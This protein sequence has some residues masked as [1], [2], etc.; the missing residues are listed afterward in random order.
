MDTFVDSSWYFYRYCDPHN[1]HAAYDSG[2]VGYWFPIDQYIGGITHAILHLLY[3]R[4]WCK[5]MRDLGLVTHTEPIARLFTQGM[6]LKGGTAMSKSKGNIVGALDMAEKYGADTGR[7][8]MLF[9]NQPE[10]DLEWSE[11]S[12]E[13][14]WRFVNK[15]YRLVEQHAAELEKERKLLRKTHETLRRV[16]QDFDVRW[17]F[18]SAIALIMELHNEIHAAEP[19]NEGVRPEVRKEVLELLTLML[20]PLTPHLA[21]ELWEM[22][23][24]AGGLGIVKWPAFNA[25]LAKEDEVEIVVQVNGRVRGK[26]VVAAGLSEAGVVS[27][28]LADPAV[29]HHLNGREVVKRIVV[30]DKLVNLVVK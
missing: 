19:L 1:D 14:A 26:L 6:V 11:D 18:N 9:A 15:V 25:E 24:Q 16:T 23:G 12:I 8:Y 27:K 22:L 3:S 30:R 4:F 21:E 7:L 17:H 10:K 5:V 20:A 29:A 28:A 13:G 2:K